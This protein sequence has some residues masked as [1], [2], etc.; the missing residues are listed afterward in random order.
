MS[1]K[2]LRSE[3]QQLLNSIGTEVCWGWSPAVDFASL[4]A[5]RPRRTGKPSPPAHKKTEASAN[6]LKA[7]SATTEITDAKS[8]EELEFEALLAQVRSRKPE[9][10]AQPCAAFDSKPRAPSPTS[11]DAPAAA[12]ATNSDDADTAVYVLLAGACDIRH[13][14]RTLATLRASEAQA[15]APSTATPPTYH[16]YLYEPNLR[17]HCR[18]LFFLQWL[19]DSMFALEELEERVLMFLDVYGNSLMREMTAA[20][21]RNVVQRLRKSLET[22]ASELQK[23]VSFEEMKYKERDFVES[24]LSHWVCDASVCDIEEQWAQ[25]VRQ[26][27]AERFDNRDNIIDWDFVF[28]LTEYT[29]LLKFPEYRTWRNTGVAFDT[30]HINPRR[31]FSYDYKVPNKTLCFFSRTGRGTYAGDIKNGPFFSF[32]ALTD[33]AHIRHRTTDG[34]CKYGNGVISLHNVR[35]WLYTLMTGMLWP[36]ADHA[37]AW[38]DAKNYNHLPPGTPSG[39]EY[40]ATLPRVRVHLLGL[41]WDRFVLHCKEGKTPRMDAAFFGTSCT[42]F[43]TPELFQQVMCAETGVVVAETAKFIVNAEDSAK[44]AYTAKLESLAKSAG[45][46]KDEALSGLLREGTPDPRPVRGSV[47]AAQKVSESRYAQP[48]LLAFIPS[49]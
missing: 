38:D 28:H 2:Y 35:A 10:P 47:T 23:I 27:M 15:A 11:S 3:Q 34:T 14:L 8:K 44:D 46:A 29:N 7:V 22:D 21:V 12:N 30:S 17:L 41:D 13:I 26:E 36:W 5:E 18:H 19:L 40:A 39:V 6:A 42:Q 31:G 49:Q 9:A 25:R 33:N 20:Q 45:W 37:F 24:Q 16:F 1:D 43:M 48:A 32:G 4:L